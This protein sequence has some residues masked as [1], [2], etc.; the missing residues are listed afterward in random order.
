MKADDSGRGLDDV[1]GSLTGREPMPA[2][3]TASTLGGIDLEHCR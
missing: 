1:R 3:E 2:A